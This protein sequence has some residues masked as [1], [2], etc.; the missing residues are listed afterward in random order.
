MKKLIVVFCFS[1][2]PFAFVYPQSGVESDCD[3]IIDNILKVN[4]L[5]LKSEIIKYF[6][7]HQKNGYYYTSKGFWDG[8]SLLLRFPMDFEEYGD[9][10]GVKLNIKNLSTP[11]EVI[12]ECRDL[13]KN[14]KSNKEM[15]LKCIDAELAKGELSEY[16]NLEKGNMAFYTYPPRHMSNIPPPFPLFRTKL[17]FLKV[18]KEFIFNKDEDV[19]PD[20][21]VV[22]NFLKTL[23]GYDFSSFPSVFGYNFY[24]NVPIFGYDFY[25]MCLLYD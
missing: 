11:E 18:F 14:I 10:D 16:A 1:F 21:V 17:D 4:R 5:Q 13:I 2:L 12:K 8:W 22:Y 24:G 7:D 20:G 25:G 19:L 3:S 9:E 23:F 15:Y 6:Y